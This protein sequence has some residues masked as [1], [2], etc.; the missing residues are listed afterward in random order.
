MNEFNT[1]KNKELLWNL[2]N[3]SGKFT[4]LPTQL[5]VKDIFENHVSKVEIASPANISL[6]DLNKR[7][8]GSVLSEL[9][10]YKS[11][12]VL[13]KQ[14][15]DKFTSSLKSAED[16]FRNSMSAPAPPQIDFTDKSVDVEQPID[17]MD[18]LLAQQLEKRQFDIP[19]INNTD[20][21]AVQDWI[22]GAS[23]K[24]PLG[25]DSQ[26]GTVSKNIKIGDNINGGEIQNSII[27]I[28]PSKNPAV[29]AD[30]RGV[31][32]KRVSWEDEKPTRQPLPNLAEITG[33]NTVNKSSIE[34]AL[35][36]I[37]KNQDYII[38][39]IHDLQ[40]RI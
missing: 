9:N 31:S 26:N 40:D 11:P 12:D 10:R 23:N 24:M 14:S 21:S 6:V 8:L 22:N 18:S 36:K 7:F 25:D 33:D 32:S 27:E 2:L 4:N 16:S 37:L 39:A 38:N 35:L 13:R 28:T 34:E 5:N 30:S 15:S 20:Q 3:T 1:N 17:D 29:V 19:T